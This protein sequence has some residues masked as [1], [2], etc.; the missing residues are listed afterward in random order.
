MRTLNSGLTIGIQCWMGILSAKFTHLLYAVLKN[1]IIGLV[2]DLVRFK[3][4]PGLTPFWKTGPW[5]FVLTLLRLLDQRLWPCVYAM[6][7]RFM[8]KISRPLLWDSE[9]AT[10]QIFSLTELQS[11]CPFSPS[12]AAATGA[13]IVDLCSL[14]VYYQQY[15][16]RGCNDSD[17]DNDND[18]ARGRG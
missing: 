6:W 15:F 16:G 1:V 13:L 18:S 10:V 8:G 12:Q 4:T 14:S 3:L 2:A 7:A 11:T 17:D 5:K 9:E